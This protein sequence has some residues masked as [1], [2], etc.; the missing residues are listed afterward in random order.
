MK[1]QQKGDKV[2]L[3]IGGHKYTIIENDKLEHDG[4]MLLGMHD[5]RN[6]EIRLDKNLI[7]SR[8]METLIHE[9]VHV[10]LTN[11]GHEHNEDWIDGVAN[12]LH[13]IGVGEYIWKQL[14]K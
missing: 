8:K 7:H 9:I 3:D 11:A 13:Q 10:V 2:R 5:A 1:K 4:K 12:G 14:K 6:C